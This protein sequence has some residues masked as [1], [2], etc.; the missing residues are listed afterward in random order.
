MI[1]ATDALISNGYLTTSRLR[2]SC[3]AI[4]G[5]TTYV[6]L[7]AP[8]GEPRATAVLDWE[9]SGI[10]HPL[11]DFTPITCWP[12]KRPR[13][14]SARPVWSAGTWRRLAFWAK[15][16]HVARYCVRTG[17]RGGIAHREFCSVFNRPTKSH[18]DYGFCS[19]MLSWTTAPTSRRVK[20]GAMAGTRS[21]SRRPTY[22]IA[23]FQLFQEQSACAQSDRLLLLLSF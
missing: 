10:V 5:W 21:K 16:E 14:A 12:G 17:R 13:S 4:S 8:D 7:H 9:V 23:S 19:N 18:V 2:A 1:E 22:C 15:G 11:A 3:T 20:D 6:V